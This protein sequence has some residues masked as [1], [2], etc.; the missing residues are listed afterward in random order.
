MAIKTCLDYTRNALYVVFYNVLLELTQY[1]NL[2]MLGK[3][4]MEGKISMN[5]ALKL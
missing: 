5:K 1:I 4:V 3:R 2:N